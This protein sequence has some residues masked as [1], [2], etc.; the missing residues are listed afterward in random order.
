LEGYSASGIDV[1]GSRILPVTASI[2]AF[3]TL[4]LH[5]TEHFWLFEGKSAKKCSKVVES[6]MN[7]HT[8]V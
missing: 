1:L 3:L 6:G 2:P 8:F 5:F 4:F 7:L